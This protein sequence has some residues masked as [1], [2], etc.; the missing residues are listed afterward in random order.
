MWTQRDHTGLMWVCASCGGVEEMTM[1][2]PVCRVPMRPPP[3]G[4][5]DRWS[6]PWCK[7]MAAS[8]ESPAEIEDR[9]RQRRD[10]LRLLDETICSRSTGY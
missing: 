5:F 10:A 8:G 3:N 7:R 9:E 2:C 6:C 4:W 1:E